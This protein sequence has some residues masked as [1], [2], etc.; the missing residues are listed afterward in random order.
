MGM[1]GIVRR[2]D[3]LGRIVIPKSIREACGIEENMPLEIS[4]ADDGSITLT[5]YT[6]KKWYEVSFTIS[7]RLSNQLVE[8]D[9]ATVA[10]K[11]EKLTEELYQRCRSGFPVD[12]QFYIAPRYKEL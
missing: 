5:P 12:A 9:E 8:A 1:T 11:V 7:G 10:E 4:Y 2:I 6:P 3:E